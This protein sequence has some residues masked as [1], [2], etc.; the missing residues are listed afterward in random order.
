MP[1]NLKIQKIKLIKKFNLIIILTYKDCGFAFDA[2]NASLDNKVFLINYKTGEEVSTRLS[3]ESGQIPQ[4]ILY[5][6]HDETIVIGTNYICE[7][8]QNASCKLHFYSLIDNNG[9]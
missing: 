5:N 6:E 8:T 7:N 3:F 1:Q 2:M 9:I 4:Q